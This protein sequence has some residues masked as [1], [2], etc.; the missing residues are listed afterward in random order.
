MLGW[1]ED[2][3]VIELAG[4]QADAVRQLCGPGEIHVTDR[5]HVTQWEDV[6]ATVA[7]LHRDRCV[8]A[9]P[10]VKVRE[11]PHKGDAPCQ[12]NLAGMTA[13]YCSRA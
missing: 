1:D 4:W 5:G 7:R 6:I 11:C 13:W 8:N 10:A 12:K 2:G 3:E 9:S